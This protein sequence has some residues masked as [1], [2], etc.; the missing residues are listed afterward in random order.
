MIKRDSTGKSTASLP[1]KYRTPIDYDTIQ[2]VNKNTALFVWVDELEEEFQHA[3][4]LVI[5]R[6]LSKERERWGQVVL[7]NCFDVEIGEYIVVEKTSEPFGALIGGLEHW[8][9]E[10]DCILYASK[11]KSCT[12]TYTGDVKAINLAA[13]NRK[14]DLERI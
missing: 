8:L 12:E 9:V 1:H 14:A 3:S 2:L 7:S 11:D 13:I 4:G 6:T 10:R 5:A